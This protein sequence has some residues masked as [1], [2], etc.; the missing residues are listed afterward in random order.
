M[1]SMVMT[2]GNGVYDVEALFGTYF[3][4]AGFA[5]GADDNVGGGQRSHKLTLAE[6]HA[7]PR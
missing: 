5:I 6:I 2:C 7:C 3:V 1:W 4:M